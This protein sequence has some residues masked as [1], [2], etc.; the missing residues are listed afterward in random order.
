MRG[1]KTIISL[2]ILLF[3]MAVIPL[4]VIL[5][6]RR[7]IRPRAAELPS[8]LFFAPDGADHN[9]GEEFTVNIALNTEGT[10]VDGLDVLVGAINLDVK[11]ATKA[12]LPE[13]LSF[14]K[15]PE[16]STGRV[17]FSILADPTTRFANSQAQT[18]VSLTLSGKAH[19]T[20]AKLIFDKNFTIVAA[21]GKNI[22]GNPKEAV[23][24]IKSPEGVT[25]PEFTS[26][27]STTAQV[28]QPMV[29]T[30]TATNPNNGSLS[31]TYYN[32]PDW[33]TAEGPTLTGTPINTGVFEVGIIVEDGKGGSACLNLK[34]EVIDE[35]EIKISAVGAGPVAYNS[36]TITWLT[37]R[38]STSQVEY[39]KTTD[40]NQETILDPALDMHHR[41][42]L[43]SLEPNTTYHFRVKS[44]APSAPSEATSED[45]EF[46]TS[47]K[48]ARVLNLKLQME[49]K[50]GNQ[51]NYPVR[52]FA[53]DVSWKVVFTPNANGSYPLSLD[54]FPEDKT[55]R[56]DFLLKGYQHLQVKRT[57]E[58]KKEEFGFPADFGILP[59][60][61]V[62]PSAQ[63]DNYVNA[64]DYSVLVS[65]WNLETPSESIADFNSDLFVNSLDYSIMV[66][67]FNKEGDF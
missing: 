61:D 59:A 49:G 35:R 51:N 30:A 16:I 33:L 41:I 18:L 67:N 63:P 31:F 47:G 34:I 58:I 23:F 19:C 48:P 66:N 24:N 39:G 42:T 5:V 38:P 65:E 53:R 26:P 11:G 4:G 15:E 25:N 50:K 7:V 44:T 27:E 56:I 3:L 36:A 54:D 13:N 62:A 22:L 52:I 2:I 21:Q 8:P 32:L 45:Q 6:Q 55:G 12:D 64:M 17:S 9:V 40:Y 37:N 57:V 43:E 14:V 20:K 28:D 46:T 60:R 10:L 1:K 29:Y